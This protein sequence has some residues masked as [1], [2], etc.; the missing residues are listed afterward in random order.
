MMRCSEIARLLASDEWRDSSLIRRLQIR[1]HLWMCRDCR[2]YGAQLT[3][4]GRVAREIV[5]DPSDDK[6]ILQRL[7]AAILNDDE[8]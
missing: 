5:L 4:M 2:G 6:A 1:V 7:R 8:S 3:A